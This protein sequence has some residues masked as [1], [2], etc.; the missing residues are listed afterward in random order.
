MKIVALRFIDASHSK[1]NIV[2]KALGSRGNPALEWSDPH[3]PQTRGRSF[4]P[5]FFVDSHLL[6]KGGARLARLAH[7]VYDFSPFS[8]A[9]SS[10]LSPSAAIRYMISNHDD[11]QN[12]THNSRDVYCSFLDEQCLG[13]AKV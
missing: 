13:P 4:T 7:T 6:K 3:R 1:E 9:I 5:V 10:F 2:M 11:L 8:N 12:T